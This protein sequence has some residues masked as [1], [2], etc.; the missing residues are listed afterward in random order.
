M[1]PEFTDE[2]E[3][4][5]GV[6]IADWP[7]FQSRFCGSSLRRQWLSGRLRTLLELAASTGELRRVFVWGS[8]VTAKPAPKDLDVL[9][10]MGQDFEVDRVAP[11]AQGVF[12]SVR[13]RLMFKADVFWARASI[14]DEALNLWL[15]IRTKYPG[16]SESAV[17]WS[18]SC[19]DRNRRPNA[20]GAAVYG[21][22]TENPLGRPQGPLAPRLRSNGGA[23]PARDP[24]ARAGDPRVFEQGSGRA[25][26]GPAQRDLVPGV[27]QYRPRITRLL[28]L[29]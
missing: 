21:Q 1:L 18:W 3:L 16:A 28:W 25:D 23:N 29:Q 9:L 4:P 12:D 15:N 8:I 17:S 27:E 19:R 22:F 6:H 13:A 26:R 20:A 10:I 11:P 24:A 14:G 2:G 7:E 5:P